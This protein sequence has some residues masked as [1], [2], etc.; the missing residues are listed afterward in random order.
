MNLERIEHV[1]ANGMV[2]TVHGE[3]I[4]GAVED[5]AELI[6]DLESFFCRYVILPKLTVLPLALWTMMTY[7]FTSFDAVPYLVICSPT[8]RCGKT[9][10]LECLELVVSKA[11]RASNISEAALFRI[12]QKF[13]PTLLLDEAETIDGK[14]ERA[15]Y[16]R[17]ILNGG[18]RRGAFVTRCDKQSLNVEDFSVFCP[19]VL[20]GI[21]N[22]SQTIMDRA[23]VVEMQRRRESEGVARF[24][25][26]TAQPEGSSLRER[27]NRFVALRSEEVCAAYEAT[28]LSFISDRDA[29]AWGPLFAILSVVAVER[30][31][32]LRECAEHLTHAKN[33]NAEDDSRTLRLLADVRD[34]WPV[35][36]PHIFSAELVRRLRGIEDGPW[37]NDEK[38]DQRKLSRM[39]RPF[40]L[41]AGTVR[42]GPE[43]KKGYTR[44]AA[45]VVFARYLKAQPSQSSQP[46]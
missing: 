29:E 7:T 13:S 42:I 26:R 35:E 21:G 12:I 1:T 4:A 20:A 2:H 18:N 31:P 14:S 27:A 30:L 43:T 38:F 3:P 39:L 33:D 34:V 10:L 23:I 16:L 46:A 40:G 41:A 25:Y 28:E 6:R 44:E 9:R 11:R 36:E 15:E 24:L 45:G 17:Q 32:E 37:A 19:K 22:R 8:P 5:G